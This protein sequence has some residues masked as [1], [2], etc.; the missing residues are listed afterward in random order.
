MARADALVAS[1]RTHGVSLERVAGDCRESLPIEATHPGEPVFVGE[2]L[3]N[4]VCAECKRVV[5]RGMVRVGSGNSDS[6]IPE[7]LTT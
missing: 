3:L 7:I 1:Q 4:Y 6:R 5:C 2:G